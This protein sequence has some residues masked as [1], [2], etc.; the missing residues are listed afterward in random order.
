MLRAP[1]PSSMDTPPWHWLSPT[2]LCNENNPYLNARGPADEDMLQAWMAW[3]DFVYAQDTN[4]CP[5]PRPDMCA[6]G[7]EGP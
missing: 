2:R 7:E 4:R 6:L 5:S 3:L 1:R